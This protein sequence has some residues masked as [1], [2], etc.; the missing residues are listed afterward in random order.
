MFLVPSCEKICLKVSFCY[1]V[2]PSCSLQ[3][4][5][6]CGH[7]GETYSS[8]CAALAAGTTID[9]AGECR[10]FGNLTREQTFWPR[11]L[12]PFVHVILCKILRQPS[13]FAIVGQQRV[14]KLVKRKQL[15]KILVQTV[16]IARK[17]FNLLN[18]NFCFSSV[19]YFSINFYCL[20]GK[21]VDM[22]CYLGL[23]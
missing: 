1:Y 17:T 18:M 12:E 3:S 21:E 4:G 23:L 19:S 14:H 13:T 10:A 5:S 8:E 22:L 11:V 9:Y 7:D 15:N 6:V 2:Q 16:W 20:W